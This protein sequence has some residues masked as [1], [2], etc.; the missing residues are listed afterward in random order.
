MD[1]KT[2]GLI[3]RNLDYI[4]KKTDITEGML[5][6]LDDFLPKS[7]ED[8]AL[9]YVLGSLKRYAREVIRMNKIL[10]HRKNTDVTDEEEMIIRDM[11]RRRIPEFLDKINRELNR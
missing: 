6:L 5:W 4:I 7:P 8:L 2:R 10:K 11:L 1:K 3:E 9:G